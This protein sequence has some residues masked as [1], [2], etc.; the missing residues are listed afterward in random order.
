MPAIIS[1]FPFYLVNVTARRRDGGTG[2]SAKV[3]EMTAITGC[4]CLKRVNM[5]ARI[6]TRPCF[7][8]DTMAMAIIT[9]GGEGKG[10]RM[11][12]LVHV[13]IIHLSIPL[14]LTSG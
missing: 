2:Y 10:V 7:P 12:S 11:Q 14:P 1:G 6:R 8:P 9:G 4:L 13:P 3:M 5:T